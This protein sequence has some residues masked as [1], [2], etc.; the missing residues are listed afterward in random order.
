[1]RVK[2]PVRRHH[3][4]AVEG[5]V[6]GASGIVVPAESPEPAVPEGLV[7]E[8]PDKA[9]LVFRILSHKVPV[10]LEITA[11][12]THGVGVLALDER[13]PGAVFQISDTAVRA[14]VHGTDY[15]REVPVMGIVKGPFVL[16]GAGRV[17][18]LDPVVTGLEIGAEAGFVA[19]TPYNDGRM[20]PVPLH[21]SLVADKVGGSVHRYLGQGLF[22]VAHSV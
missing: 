21:H 2:A 17:L 5:S 18:C 4:V 12:V 16:Y 7:L 10:V 22:P 14:H 9:A 1:M 3:A 15:V 11:G 8:V 20:V 13:L 6:R 19:H